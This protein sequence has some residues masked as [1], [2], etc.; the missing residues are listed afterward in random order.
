MDTALCDDIVSAFAVLV[1]PGRVT[2]S[3]EDR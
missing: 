2:T 3:T 1:L